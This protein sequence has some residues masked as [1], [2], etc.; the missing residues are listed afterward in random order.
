MKI[1]ELLEKEKKTFTC[2]WCKKNFKS[3]TGKF[4]PH[5][6]RFQDIQKVNE[7][8][9]ELPEDVVKAF[10][11]LGEEQRG[12]PEHAMLKVQHLMG[13]GVLNPVVEHVGDLTNRMT[14]LSKY[15]SFGYDMFA[16]KVAKT[17]RW[18]T[19]S[20]GFEKEFAENIKNNAAHRNMDPNE[21]KEMLD[22][23]LEAYSNAHSKLPVYN[24][25]QW[26]ARQAAID[27]GHQNFSG[28][29][30]NLEYLQYVIKDVDRYN[31]MAS[32]V[33]RTPNGDIMQYKP[34][35]N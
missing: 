13:G 5:C 26:V 34:G 33:H 23:A 35:R 8:K 21:L 14:V 24:K 22:K 31:K 30:S 1:F 9:I 2:K 18:L 12:A 6:A 11:H 29:V 28:A 27:L 20:Y 32:E 4:C 16:D 7:D 25:L 15:G 10:T 17:L 3:D 19:N